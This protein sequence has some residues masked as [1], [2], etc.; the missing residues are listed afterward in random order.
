LLFT[1]KPYVSFK[2]SWKQKPVSI[3]PNQVLSPALTS[4]PRVFL[5]TAAA[6]TSENSGTTAIS[7]TLVPSTSASMCY[8]GREKRGGG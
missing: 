8:V 6:L 7:V 5:R 3:S 1:S 4:D 2:S